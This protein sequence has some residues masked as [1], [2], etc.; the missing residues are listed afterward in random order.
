MLLSLIITILVNTN[1]K[2]NNKK[3]FLFHLLEY[4]P[5]FLPLMSSV[6]VTNMLIEKFS[7]S[8]AKSLVL[9]YFG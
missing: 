7:W 4:V 1:Q 3:R 9:I 8:R 6:S 2:I 5:H